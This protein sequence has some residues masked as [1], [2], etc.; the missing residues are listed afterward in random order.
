MKKK[1]FLF[2]LLGFGYL[3][4]AQGISFAPQT[5][6][7][8]ANICCVADMNGDFLDDIVT[9]SSTQIKIYSQKTNVHNGQ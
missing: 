4:N 8:S 1:Y 7:G 6:G 2:T 5:F 9:V 3:A